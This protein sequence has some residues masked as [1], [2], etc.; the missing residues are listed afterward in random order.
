MKKFTILFIFLF[1]LKWTLQAQDYTVSKAQVKNGDIS[2]ATRLFIPKNSLENPPPVVII[3]HG[4]GDNAYWPV[5]EPVIERCVQQG[6]AVAFFDKRGTGE[7]GGKYPNISLKKSTSI[8][9]TLSEDV[10]AVAEW[11]FQQ[12][13]I[14]QQRIG[15]YA[16]SQGG[17]IAPLAANQSPHIRFAI[18]VSGPVCSLG[19]E[20]LYSKLAGDEKKNTALSL[21]AINEE[22]ANFEGTRGFD[23]YEA[24]AQMNIPALWLFG[25]EDRSMPVELS[26]NNLEKIIQ[27]QPNKKFTY[28]IY[29]Q[30]NHSLYDIQAQKRLP[31]MQD[32][33]SWLVESL[34]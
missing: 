32:V 8:F 20:K 17:W 30:A 5:Y 16:L 10:V 12:A 29:P 18:I 2:L 27:A 9:Q 23:S 11:L 4:S 1:L 25:E 28:K 19:H 24:V 3:V 33:K 26:K 34:Y 7:S 31:Y 6:M 15:L 22:V 14:D 13:E 21:K